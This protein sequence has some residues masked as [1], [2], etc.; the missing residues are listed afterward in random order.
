[1]LWAWGGVGERGAPRG[2]S[3]PCDPMGLL[4]SGGRGRLE[5]KTGSGVR[6]QALALAFLFG[7]FLLAGPLGGPL[8]RQ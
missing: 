6:S 8:G 3:A 5:S 2:C 4:Y 1:M 7:K